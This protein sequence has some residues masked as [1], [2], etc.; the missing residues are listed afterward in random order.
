MYSCWRLLERCTVSALFT[1]RL[2][3]ILIPQDLQLPTPKL[4]KLHG[5]DTFWIQHFKPIQTFHA[6][7]LCLLQGM[8]QLLCRWALSQ[9]PPMA[10]YVGVDVGA[11]SLVSISNLGCTMLH[12]MSLWSHQNA[13]SRAWRSCHF[14]VLKRFHDSVL[15]AILSHFKPLYMISVISVLEVWCWVILLCHFMRSGASQLHEDIWSSLAWARL[16][17]CTSPVLLCT[18]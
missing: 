3:N 15:Q 2:L 4:Q 14:L 17:W 11:L 5:F 6:L 9:S 13:K 7:M 18:P 8:G 12:Q 16:C 10:L 1:L